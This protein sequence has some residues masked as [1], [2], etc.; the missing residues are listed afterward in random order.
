MAGY[1]AT[2][3]GYLWSRVWAVDL[4]SVFQKAGL[5]NPEIGQRYRRTVLEPGATAE[6]EALLQAFL[7]R[8]PS[9]V[10]FYEELGLTPAPPQGR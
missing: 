9:P 5:T 7:G 3:Y 2:Y 6:P 10:A 4:A 8:P 1:D